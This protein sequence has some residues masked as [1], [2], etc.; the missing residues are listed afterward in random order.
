MFNNYYTTA[1]TYNKTEI[2][3]FITNITNQIS[4][5]TEALEEC[6]SCDTQYRWITLT[7]SSDTDSWASASFY[8]DR[9]IVTQL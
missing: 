8:L 3:E 5:L 4:A 1:N 9:D 2:N 7:G 6:C